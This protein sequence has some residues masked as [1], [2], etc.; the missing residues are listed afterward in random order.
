MHRRF[1][2]HGGLYADLACLG[3]RNCP[4]IKDNEPPP[5]ALRNISEFLLI[6]NEDATVENLQL[7][8]THLAMH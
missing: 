3:P 2:Q 1:L 7:E 5:N 8:L 6:L 4:L